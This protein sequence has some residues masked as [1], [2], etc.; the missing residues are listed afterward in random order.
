MI[1]EIEWA[2]NYVSDLDHEWGPLLF[3]RPERRAPMTSPRVAALAVLYGVLVG[4]AVNVVVRLTGE[5][6]DA[7]NPLFFPAATTI[8]FFAFYRLTFAQ[9]WNRRAARL[10]R[11][12]R[13]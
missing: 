3:L 5:H 2:L 12:A 4:C 1:E 10:R 11:G 7:L 13:E 8:V 6:A 9:C